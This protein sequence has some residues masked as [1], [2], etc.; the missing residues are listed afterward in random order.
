MTETHACNWWF[1]VCVTC[2]EPRIKTPT[3]KESTK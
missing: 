3:P 1:G 2:G